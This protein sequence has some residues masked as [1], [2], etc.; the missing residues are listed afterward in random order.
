MVSPNDWF[1]AIP[2]VRWYPGASACE[3]FT[4]AGRPLSHQSNLDE[5]NV[6][7][8]RSAVVARCCS[9]SSACQM[10]MQDFLGPQY[11][12]VD[13]SGDLDVSGFFNNDDNVGVRRGEPGF[14]SQRCES[15]ALPYGGAFLCLPFHQTLLT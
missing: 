15:L 8:D 7:L 3:G 10:G 12:T 9:G 14:G 13:A 11:K 1:I 5:D 4:G 6:R 2:E